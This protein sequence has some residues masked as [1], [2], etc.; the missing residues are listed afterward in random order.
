MQSRVI[1]TCGVRVS[2]VGFGCVSL[3]THPRPADALELLRGAFAAGVTHFDVAPLYGRGHAEV[4]LGKFVRE[5]S[6]DRLTIATK[7]GLGKPAPALLRNRPGLIQAGRKALHF[8]RPLRGALRRAAPAPAPAAVRF[9]PAA[10]ARSLDASLKALG[11]DYVDLLLL[12][13]ADVADARA[14]ELLEHLEG[15]VRAGRVRAFGVA[16]STTRLGRD[17]RAFPRN[18]SVFQFNN[19]AVEAEIESLVGCTDRFPI[20]HSA[21]APLHWLR[22]QMPGREALLRG[23]SA[24]L[25]AD[26]EDEGVL[27]ELL[28]GYALQANEAGVVLFATMRR[29]HLQA[30]LRAFE[31]RRAPQQLRLFHDFCRAIAER[32][33]A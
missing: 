4:V 27:A 18:H 14:P 11:T 6:R 23:W 8:L 24:R 21:L 29:D 9:A 3:A 15:E 28:L 31:A 32:R 2:R 20:T 13:E 22:R 16:S 19:S 7:F 1:S 17:L 33:A 30:N 10:A 25:D 5:G 12:H 26:L